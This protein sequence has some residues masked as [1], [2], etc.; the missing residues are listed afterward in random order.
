MSKEYLA[1][2]GRTRFKTFWP[3]MF[4]S[5]FPE[6]DMNLFRHFTVLSIKIVVAEKDGSGSRE[7]K[8]ERDPIKEAIDLGT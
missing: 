2:A 7:F 5:F 6:I 8:Y 3:A 4:H 1:N